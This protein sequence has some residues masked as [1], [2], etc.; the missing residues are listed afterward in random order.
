MLKNAADLS[1]VS[2]KQFCLEAAK[3]KAD[4]AVLLHGDKSSSG[5][6]EK[7]RWLPIFEKTE[8]ADDPDNPT[9]ERKMVWEVNGEGMVRWGVKTS[10]E[11]ALKALERLDALREKIFQGRVSSTDSADLI[12]EGREERHWDMEGHGNS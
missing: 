12:R 3:E 2:L 8:L 9:R 7:D 6:K 1:S 11:E 4:L 10:K 5:D